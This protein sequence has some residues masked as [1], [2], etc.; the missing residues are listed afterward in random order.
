M[1]KTV[2][3]RTNPRCGPSSRPRALPTLFAALLS[4]PSASYSSKRSLKRFLDPKENFAGWLDYRN[5]VQKVVTNPQ[6]FQEL[7]EK[8]D[9]IKYGEP[10]AD[11]EK[12]DYEK[13]RMVREAAFKRL[14]SWFAV[15][16]KHMA[17][18]KPTFLLD[19]PFVYKYL[20]L[21]KDEDFQD[22]YYVRKIVER[23]L[24]QP[25]GL[26][27]AV[28]VV[29]L[30]KGNGTLAM[31]AVMKYVRDNH[32]RDII[33]KLLNMFRKEGVRDNEYT[34]SCVLPKSGT[35]QLAPQRQGWYITEYERHLEKFPNH[36]V[37]NLVASNQ[38]F[39]VMCQRTSID[40]AYRFYRE[41]TFDK[42]E[43][44]FTMMLRTF[45][46]TD[47][48]KKESWMTEIEDVW[49]D[50]LEFVKTKK[51]QLDAPLV[52]AYISALRYHAGPQLIQRRLSQYFLCDQYIPAIDTSNDE[53][54][55]DS[56]IRRK[57]P[58]ETIT[59]AALL[60]S[61]VKQENYERAM[62]VFEQERAKKVIDLTFDH[63]RLYI[64]AIS[65]A[66]DVERG[67]R[68][69]ADMKKNRQVKESLGD[70]E[71]QE[72]SLY[73]KAT[74]ESQDKRMKKKGDN[75]NIRGIRDEKRRNTG[76]FNDISLE[77]TP[78]RKDKYI[79]PL[80]STAHISP[81]FDMFIRCDPS[82]IRLESVYDLVSIAQ[83]TTYPDRLGFTFLLAMLRFNHY[84]LTLDSDLKREYLRFWDPKYQAIMFNSFEFMLDALFSFCYNPDGEV[85]T[86]E[87][88]AYLNKVHNR[89]VRARVIE[90]L[91]NRSAVME[92]GKSGFSHEEKREW[93]SRYNGV[94]YAERKQE[95]ERDHKAVHRES[96]R[97]KQL[98][99][100]PPASG[101]KAKMPFDPNSGES[102]E[103]LV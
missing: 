28:T 42:D 21:R 82:K 85:L 25:N 37:S 31:N 12:P 50:V 57:F 102:L 62:S 93:M 65:K 13:L 53:S 103:L 58:L 38:L 10:M 1:L 44:T 56:P 30:A 29:R 46:F 66:V 101:R 70:D 23:F 22:P 63:Y 79:M 74:A 49:K 19:H 61:F 16:P 92:K 7:E 95:K 36:P 94:N 90:D 91:A 3:R 11:K 80:L 73:R 6:A 24:R 71:R 34:F 52:A 47:P 33:A 87:I 69:I 14:D 78:G 43:M 17:G 97:R 100:T 54:S 41:R 55:M 15:D 83:K 88:S 45:A 77:E 4:N 8:L 64:Q 86:K 96:R 89:N 75:K 20:G 5:Q 59:F 51:V 60:E 81:L 32:R 48:N 9:G 26:P 76:Y 40:L 35:G 2:L 99:Q 98:Q 18:R 68:L 39:Q 84:A 67:E 27:K 72:D